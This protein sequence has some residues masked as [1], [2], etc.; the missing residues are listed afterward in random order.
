[1]IQQNPEL[2]NLVYNGIRHSVH[3]GGAE[4]NRRALDR[5]QLH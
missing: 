4:T 2:W 1:V 5:L 3:R